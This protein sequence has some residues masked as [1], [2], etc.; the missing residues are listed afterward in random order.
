MLEGIDRSR[1]SNVRRAQAL[2][3][4]EQADLT[5]AKLTKHRDGTFTARYRRKTMNAPESYELRLEKSSDHPVA[6][7]KR[8]NKGVD[9][10]PYVTM[11]FAFGPP[12]PLRKV[13]A[14]SK[15]VQNGSA[16]PTVMQP[17]LLALLG[18]IARDMQQL[19]REAEKMVREDA[20]QEHILVL[21]HELQRQSGDLAG[22]VDRLVLAG[23]PA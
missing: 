22:V 17:E 4:L 8:P 14:S 16:A 5:P 21:L 15:S 1:Y 12:E 7:F 9:R 11:Q 18:G 6:I 19:S 20:Q 2:R 23:E 13:R 10:G 3:L